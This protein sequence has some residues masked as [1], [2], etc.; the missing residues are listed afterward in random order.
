M[1]RDPVL[2]RFDRTFDEAY[3]FYEADDYDRA[4]GIADD[5][6]CEVTLPRYYPSAVYLSR[7]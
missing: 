4:F 6:L 2:E 1:P 7:E 3:A 5:M